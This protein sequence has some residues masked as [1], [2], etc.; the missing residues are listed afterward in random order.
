MRPAQWD[1]TRYVSPEQDMAPWETALRTLLTDAAAYGRCA[2]ASRRAATAFAA[3]AR[4]EV[5]EAFLRAC[6]DGNHD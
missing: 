6:A 4:V 2:E 1:G 5:F 3:G